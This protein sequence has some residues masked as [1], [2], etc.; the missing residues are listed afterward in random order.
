LQKYTEHINEIESLYRDNLNDIPA[1]A[2]GMWEDFEKQLP[3]IGLSG[4]SNVGTSISTT[5]I[6]N[7]TIPWLKLSVGL[8]IILTGCLCYVLTK[9]NTEQPSPSADHE[10]TP[11]TETNK[12]IPGFSEKKENVVKE[13][14]VFNGERIKEATSKQYTNDPMQIPATETP[15]MP[16]ETNGLMEKDIPLNGDVQTGVGVKNQ[17]AAPAQD[18]SASDDLKEYYK[19]KKGS[20][21]LFK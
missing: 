9:I 16:S 6:V 20:K 7:S 2:A 13:K 14:N 5:S 11:I 12:K 4:A 18:T 15:V 21:N 8:N 1:D 19:G 10:L 3:S 17:Q